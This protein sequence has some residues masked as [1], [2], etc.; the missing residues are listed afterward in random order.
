LRTLW[1]FVG[2]VFFY[3]FL[4]FFFGGV[5]FIFTKGNLKQEWVFYLLIIATFL[6]T[7]LAVYYAR[8]LLDRRSFVSLGLIWNKQAGQDLVFGFLV[9]GLIIGLI[10]LVERVAGWLDFAGFVWD[11]ISATRVVQ[12]TV[13]MFIMFILVGINEELLYRGYVLQNITDGMNLFWGFLLSSAVFS[14]NHYA[15]PNFSLEAFVGLF[16]SGLFLAYPYLRTRQL[17]LSFGLHIGWNFFEGTIFGFQV[18]G[19]TNMPRLIMQTVRGPVLITGGEFGPE[20]G[21][22]L[23]PALLLGACLIYLY[24]HSRNKDELKAASNLVIPPEEI[25]H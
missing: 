3:L 21:L 7:C 5:L 6:G 2:F 10:F 13:L 8:R 17:W 24:T 19:L 14:L 25:I 4:N 18:S 12:G 1:R 11:S 23:M 15:N 16:V 22:V 9:T 20:A